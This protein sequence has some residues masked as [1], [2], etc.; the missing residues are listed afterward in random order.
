MHSIPVSY[1]YFRCP[2]IGTAVEQQLNG[3]PTEHAGTQGTK[4]QPLLLQAVAENLGVGAEA[5]SDLELCLADYYP[6]VS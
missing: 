1:Y 4:H 2:I 6:A 5:I 3:G